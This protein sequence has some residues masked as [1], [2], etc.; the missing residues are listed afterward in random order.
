MSPKS[1]RMT[2]NE[3]YERDNFFEY[4]GNRSRRTIDVKDLKTDYGELIPVFIYDTL[5]RGQEESHQL[6][7]YPFFGEATTHT[8]EF[9]VMKKSNNILM[10]Y[11]NPTMKRE[12]DLIATNEKRVQGELYGV[13]LDM[14]MYL[15]RVY[16]NM[17]DFDRIDIPVILHQ[18]KGG[19]ILV[20]HAMTYTASYPFWKQGV[21]RM[22]VGRTEVS[23][24]VMHTVYKPFQHT[25]KIYQPIQSELDY[26]P[27]GRNHNGGPSNSEAKRYDERSSDLMADE[28][29]DYNNWM[30]IG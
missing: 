19:H 10:F 17:N 3:K 24:H 9:V 16:M 27:H 28:M 25:P 14:L 6:E 8:D 2:Y 29:D 1:S 26:G 11:P 13:P 23:D 20:R 18:K 15:D 7:S 22:T 30:G 4:L 12:Q 5:M 21:E